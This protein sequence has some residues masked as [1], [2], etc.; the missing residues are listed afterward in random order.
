MKIWLLTTEY[1]PYFGGG[2]ATYAGIIT[3]EWARLGHEVTVIVRD[4]SLKT[5]PLDI[6]QGPVRVIRFSDAYPIGPGQAL[7]GAAQISWT[8]A[9]VVADRIRIGERPD[10]IESQD[11]L[12]IPYYLLQRRWTG[13]PLFQGIPVVVTVHSPKFV[14]DRFD[15]APLYR[16]PDYWIG[17]LEQA[18]IKMADAVVCPSHYV[19]D[20]LGPLV[21]QPSHVIPNPYRLPDG[22]GPVP[23]RPAPRILYVGRVQKVKGILALLAAMRIVWERRPEVTLDVV[24]GDSYFAPRAIWMTDDLKT[25]YAAD[26]RQGRLTFHG[27]KPPAAVKEFLRRD[28]LVVVPSLYENFPYTVV[29]AMAEARVVLAS[30]TGGQREIIR[31]GDNGFLMRP[32]R[33]DELAQHILT[34]LALPADEWFRIGQAAHA[35]IAY[36]CEPERIATRKLAVF[37]DVIAGS[38][39]SEFPFLTASRSVAS[40]PAESTRLS[41]VIPYYNMGAYVEETLQ[42]VYQSRV[43]PDEVLIVNDGSTDP[44]SVALLYQLEERYPKLRVI[45][46]TNQGLA[47]ARN[48]G[49]R[50]AQGQYLAFLDADDQVD[51][52]YWERAVA[53]LEAYPNVAF[54]GAWAQYFGASEQIWPTFNPEL[55]YILYHNTVNSSALIVRKAVFEA[56]GGN[57]PAMTYGMED[58]E[59]VI[60]LVAAGY[61]GVVIPEPL[62]RYRIRPDSMS[63]GFNRHNLLYLYQ[64]LTRLNADVYERH[65]VEVAN[66]LNANG[67]QYLAD[68]P[69][70][71]TPAVAGSFTPLTPQPWWKKAA[72]GLARRLL[73]S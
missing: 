38:P 68:T 69:L 63:R 52:T 65:A 15:D 3:Q 2:I 35:T 62:F 29:E 48:T 25:R 55:P 54:V 20:Q 57:N 47:S 39:H 46:Q 9:A 7:T 51:P 37:E 28:G 41:V 44:A 58:W 73:R 21:T 36:V 66:L 10:V 40:V 6:Q 26:I 34:L 42:S 59:T 31:P 64:T 8:Y 53:L 27:L 50:H 23:A 56:V 49:A 43:P 1:P 17:V 71:E 70:R 67:P 13:D 16:L 32:D 33:A 60:R 24:G 5:A 22:I 11:Y 19:R 30:E 61:P 14:V 12:G 4:P 18:S 45:R 72:R